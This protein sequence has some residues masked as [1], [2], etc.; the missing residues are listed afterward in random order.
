MSDDD[1]DLRLRIMWNNKKWKDV[2]LEADI[3]VRI[4]DGHEYM[5]T[6]NKKTEI[7]ELFGNY[8]AH[9]P[10]V[11]KAY[12]D[13]MDMYAQELKLAKEDL[14]KF[15]KDIVNM[16]RELAQFRGTAEH[17]VP[18]E[19]VM[20]D[21]RGLYGLKSKR[22]IH[23][24]ELHKKINRMPT[25]K[26]IKSTHIQVKLAQMCRVHLDSDE[27]VY[28]YLFYCDDPIQEAIAKTEFRPDD[29]R[30]VG[31]ENETAVPWEPRSPSYSPTSPS[32]SPAYSP[33]SPS[34]EKTAWG[35]RSPPYRPSSSSSSSFVARRVPRGLEGFALGPRAD[36]GR[37][38]KRVR[39]LSEEEDVE[40]ESEQS[41]EEEGSK[42]FK[43]K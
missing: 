43:G 7:C 24:E 33:T 30:A 20:E 39:S 1:V 22:E 27:V 18:S 13:N 5:W 9:L 38:R 34:Y 31:K 25:G 14:L 4:G 17:P 16:N 40:E 12:T 28:L 23:I 21:L 6:Y 29:D 11:T 2:D 32:Y 41:E 19:R 42:K 36:A 35:A 37:D 3:P 15:Q 8:T 26:G 10:S